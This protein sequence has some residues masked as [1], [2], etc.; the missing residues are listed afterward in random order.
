M[1]GSGAHSAAAAVSKP[2]SGP[3]AFEYEAWWK[4]LLQL[5]ITEQQSAASPKR[6]V[7]AGPAGAHARPQRTRSLTL[8]KSTAAPWLTLR[9]TQSSS[10]GSGGGHA[11]PSVGRRSSNSAMLS[12]TLA[13]YQSFFTS[14]NADTAGQRN[15]L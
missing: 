4:R 2:A 1:R 5:S 11:R 10:S 6:Q 13:P 8:S 7:S 12:P 9:P 3:D 15:R 14:E